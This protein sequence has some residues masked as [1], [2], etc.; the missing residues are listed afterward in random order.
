[1]E[2]ILGV[3]LACMFVLQ[4]NNESISSCRYNYT[5]FQLTLKY[6]HRY[7]SLVLYSKDK[8][9]WKMKYES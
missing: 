9:N 8:N 5:L 3:Y 2:P 4:T 1:M 6:S 7:T